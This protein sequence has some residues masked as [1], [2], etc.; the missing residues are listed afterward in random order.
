MCSIVQNPQQISVCDV[1]ATA[2]HA[3][4]DGAT[5][6]LPTMQRRRART[7]SWE[8]NGQ[9]RWQSRGEV[10]MSRIEQTVPPFPWAR[11]TDTKLTD[12]AS[13]ASWLL[14]TAA[15]STITV[16]RPGLSLLS[17]CLE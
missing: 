13:L 2:D 3:C 4:G 17:I 15:A 8:A 5:D 11:E 6:T 1:S 9:P 7:T 10:Y 14:E 16:R 12:W